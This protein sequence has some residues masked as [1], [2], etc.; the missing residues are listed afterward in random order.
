[1]A[2]HATDG[3]V[4]MNTVIEMSDDASP[5]VWS[6]VPEPKDIDGPEVTSEFADATHMQSPAGFRERMPTVK[7]NSQVTFK[8]NKLAGNTVQD[9]M[10][11]AAN[12]NPPALKHFRMTYPDGD[13]ITFYAYISAKASS[14]MTNM[15]EWAFTLSLKGAWLMA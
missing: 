13:V 10:I 14:P 12:A 2:E 8:C 15:M 11:T 9:A 4:G 5:E 6:E 7:S 1:M 3:A